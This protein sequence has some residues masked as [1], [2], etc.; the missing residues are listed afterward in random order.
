MQ[1]IFKNIFGT[2][3]FSNIT[4]IYYYLILFAVLKFWCNFETILE[5]IVR[6]HVFLSDV[7][8]YMH[9]LLRMMVAGAGHVVQVQVA[10]LR[11][12]VRRRD[13][14]EGVAAAAADRRTG[15]RRGRGR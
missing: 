12:P 15:E 5:G 11:A 9:S 14:R 10:R 8:Q 13:V 6:L 4:Y 2:E 1:V 3:P 7:C